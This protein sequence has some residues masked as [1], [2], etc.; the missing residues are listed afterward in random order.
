MTLHK[1]PSSPPEKSGD[2]DSGMGKPAPI[3]GE[4]AGGG[5]KRPDKPRYGEPCN[6][7]GMCCIAIQCVVSVALFGEKELCPALTEAGN[8]LACGLM[9]D[10]A[11]HVPDM[12]AWGGKALTE[13]FS[14]MIGSGIGCDGQTEDEPDDESTRLAMIAKANAKIAGAS[15]EA[16]MLVNYF[17]APTTQEARHD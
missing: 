14:L 12:T 10:T 6:G 5:G 15:P 8:A 16:R 1:A 13:T 11:A 9:I 4:T 2:L 3:V 17:R 7:C